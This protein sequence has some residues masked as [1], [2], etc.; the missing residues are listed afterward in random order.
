MN[1]KTQ[2]LL[3]PVLEILPLDPEELLT[4]SETQVFSPGC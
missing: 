4:T 1:L 2:I 3:A